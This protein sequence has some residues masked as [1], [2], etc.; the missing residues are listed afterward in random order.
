[1]AYRYR[2][3]WIVDETLSRLFDVSSQLKQALRIK[4][5]SEIMKIFAN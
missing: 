2:C 5:R 3:G 1:M 4:W